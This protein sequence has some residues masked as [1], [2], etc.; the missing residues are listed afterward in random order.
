MPNHVRNTLNI[1]G[2][3]EDLD[4]FEGAEFSFQQLVPP[5]SGLQDMNLYSWKLEN[6]GTKWDRYEFVL[7]RKDE[8]ILV[9]SFDTAWDPPLLFLRHLHDL[10]PRCWFKLRWLNEDFSAGICLIYKKTGV[11][12]TQYACMRWMEPP[13]YLTTQGELLTDLEDPTYSSGPIPTL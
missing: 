4:V 6:W 12:E 3:K 2:H 7:D 9:V 1:V 5:P 10:Y 13:P 11:A 8:N